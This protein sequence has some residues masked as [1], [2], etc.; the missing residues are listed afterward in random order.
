MP[1]SRNLRFSHTMA[2]DS[3]DQ[4]NFIPTTAKEKTLNKP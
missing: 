2:T 4:L 3:S 1:F